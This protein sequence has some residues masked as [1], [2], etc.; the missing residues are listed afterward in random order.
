MDY[1]DYFKDPF[2]ASL[3]GALLTAAYLYIKQIVN[4]EAPLKVSEYVKPAVLNAILVYVIVS[5]GIG[6][7]EQILREPF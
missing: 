3:I 6:A 4:K 7:K 5:N 2:Y 1:S